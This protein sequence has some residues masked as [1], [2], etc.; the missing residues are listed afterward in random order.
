[1][2]RRLNPMQEFIE[3]VQAAFPDNQEYLTRSQLIQVFEFTGNASGY[4]QFCKTPEYKISRGLYRTSSPTTKDTK[5]EMN[6]VSKR[7][8]ATEPTPVINVA[9]TPKCDKSLVPASDPDF[10]AFGDYRIV[11]NLMKANSF[12]PV[13]IT[14]ESGNGKTKM[15]YEACAKA[16]RELI[17]AN[18]TEVTDEDDLIGGFRLVDGN[19]IWQDG[20][21]IEAMKRGAVL[22][23]DEI[24][25][26][27]PKIM[28]LQPILEGN[29]IYI[30]K[31]N[32]LV[33]PAAGFTVVATANSKGKGSS[34][35]RYMGSNILNEAF[36]DRFA[37]TIEHDYPSTVVETKILNLI[38]AKNKV[39]DKDTLEF[40]PRLI[41]WAAA[42]RHTFKEGAIDEIVT[43]RR[44]IHILNFYIFGGTKNRMKAI[45][46]CIARFDDETKVSFK[47][48]YQKFDATIGI[49]GQELPVESDVT[50]GPGEPTF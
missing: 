41:E 8:Q 38:L 36:L 43:T 13:Y 34:D 17:R 44:L 24:N 37:I 29:A 3:D 15:V 11:Y 18:I 26:G 1:M 2:K 49:A 35:G 45:E 23:L 4:Q 32:E 12:F 39:T 10:V 28:C 25:L 33:Y 7:Q 42:I 9:L 16:K 27:S 48:L 47:S 20:P 40:V 19:T 30:K 5:V 31:T 46:Y 21:A 22:L 6:I 50:F 14:G